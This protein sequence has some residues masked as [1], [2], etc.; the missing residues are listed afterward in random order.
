[1]GI[2]KYNF[3]SAVPG[4]GAEGIFGNQIPLNR[5]DLSIVFRPKEVAHGCYRKGL[6][7]HRRLLQESGSQVPSAKQ[8]HR[9]CLQSR[10]STTDMSLPL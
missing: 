4:T 5:E 10:T 9:Q 8:D 6:R 2:T 3:D 1:M 7:S